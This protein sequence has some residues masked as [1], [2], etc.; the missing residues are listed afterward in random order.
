MDGCEVMR[1][2]R[3]EAHERV[4]PTV[5]RSQPAPTHGHIPAFHN[6]EAETAFRDTRSASDFPGEVRLV[7]GSFAEGH[8]AVVAEPGDLIG[9][10]RPPRTG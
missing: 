6:I 3:G 2:S 8:E 1:P 4:E 10:A 5:A 7:A 9:Q